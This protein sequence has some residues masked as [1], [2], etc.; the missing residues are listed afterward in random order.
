MQRAKNERK[1]E[2]ET[3]SRLTSPL[4]F[5]VVFDVSKHVSLVPAFC[6]SEVEPYFVVFEH[7]AAV[8]HCVGNSLAMLANRE[9]SRCLFV[10]G[11]RRVDP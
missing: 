2:A 3:T 6:E 7:I 10:F 11:Y 5:F 9:S 1:P 4:L 8:M